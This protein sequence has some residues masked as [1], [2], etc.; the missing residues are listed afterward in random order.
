VSVGEVLRHSLLTSVYFSAADNDA[1]MVIDF[2]DMSRVPV[3]TYRPFRRAP[4]LFL[5]EV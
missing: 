2:W 1:R 5:Q 4:Y 3:E